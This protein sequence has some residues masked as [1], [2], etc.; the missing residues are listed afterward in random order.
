ME[1]RSTISMYATPSS[2]ENGT[3]CNFSPAGK[4][5]LPG[6]AGF[7]LAANGTNRDRLFA[8]E[9]RYP[10]ETYALDKNTWFAGLAWQGRPLNLKFSWQLEWERRT[11]GSRGCRQGPA[12]Y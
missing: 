12:G 7:F 3:C 4:G 9:G 5:C 8:E 10:Q 2:S 1:R 6:D 11:P